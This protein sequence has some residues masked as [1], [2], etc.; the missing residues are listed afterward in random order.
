MKRQ[1]P[2]IVRRELGKLP[3]CRRI[4]IENRFCSTANFWETNLRGER[5]RREPDKAFHNLALCAAAIPNL[6]A[7]RGLYSS[8]VVEASLPGLPATSLFLRAVS[9]PAGRSNSLGCPSRT[10]TVMGIVG[11]SVSTLT[12]SSPKCFILDLA[13]LAGVPK[14]LPGMNRKSDAK[15]C[16]QTGRRQQASKSFD[17]IPNARGQCLGDFYQRIHRRRFFSA[18]DTAD[19]NCRKVCFFSQLFLGEIGF[20]ALGANGFPQQAPMWLA[21]RHERVKDGKSGKIA[22]SLT[23]NLFLPSSKRGFKMRRKLSN[24]NGQ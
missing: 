19:K 22:M 3:I 6:L 17:Q 2:I 12:Q 14:Q 9:L 10:M 21:G 18:L 20:F 11:E 7:S 1:Q 15:S 24:A 23:T 13:L 5:P 8:R 16:S 4:E